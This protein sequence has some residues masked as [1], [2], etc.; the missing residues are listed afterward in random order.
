MKKEKLLCLMTVW[1]GLSGV[2]PKIAKKIGE[3]K[4]QEMYFS[5]LDDLI[6]G[7]KDQDY[8][9]HVHIFPKDN[10]VDF[11]ERYP[12]VEISPSGFEDIDDL[13]THIFK[14]KLKEYEKVIVIAS[15]AP[16]VHPDL[17]EDA[18]SYLSDSDF[19]IG[20]SEDG[21]VYLAGE[22]SY[23]DFVTGIDFSSP[24]SFQRI[25]ERAEKGGLEFRILET[26]MDVEEYADLEELAM[27]INEEENPR[28][29]SFLKKMGFFRY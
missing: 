13:I 5:F 23:F 11:I 28:T 9:F 22:K 6:K 29:F 16:N 7:H 10:L 8:D 18:F 20:P 14:T 12:D 25:I 19:V 26:Q 24:I 2:K 21:G 4:M 3:E 1:P 17:V 15:D 27:T